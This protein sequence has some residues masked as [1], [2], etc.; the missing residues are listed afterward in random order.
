MS[1]SSS[2]KVPGRGGRAIVDPKDWGKSEVSDVAEAKMRSSASPRARGGAKVTS[3]RS[4]LFKKAAQGAATPNSPANAM[5]CEVF[6]SATEAAA[7]DRQLTFLSCP[8]TQMCSYGKD[9][10][11]KDWARDILALCHN[12][13]RCEMLDLGVILQAFQNIREGLTIAEFSDLRGW[14]QTFN[15]IV[16]DF[17]VLEDLVMIPWMTKAVQSVS[18]P[19][20]RA[21]SFLSLSV[22][23]RQAIRMAAMQVSKAF[24]TLCDA[25]PAALREKAPPSDENAIDIVVQLDK[26]IVLTADYMSDEETSLSE[27]VS[28]EYKE[29]KERDAIL[30]AIVNHMTSPQAHRLEEFMVLQTRWMSDSKIA[31]AH[32]KVLTSIFDCPISKFQTQFELS[33][34]GIVAVFKIKGNLA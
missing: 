14:W 30:H 31:R 15:G 21:S 13:I 4:S 11:S 9:V 29:K 23:R 3:I 8:S 12:G 6:K 33:H 22:G 2:L 25:L 16:M 18:T 5:Q 19:D 27:T 34:A 1:F 7:M 17:I 26:F 10:N 32:A 20:E 24:G 28:L